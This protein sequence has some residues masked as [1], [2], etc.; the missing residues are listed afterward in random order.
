MLTDPKHPTWIKYTVQ[1]ES[2]IDILGSFGWLDDEEKA[3]RSQ[4]PWAPLIFSCAS[5]ARA[6]ILGRR[7]RSDRIRLF[8]C[9]GY[10]ESAQTISENI[11]QCQCLQKFFK[12]GVHS[13]THDWGWWFGHCFILGCLL[14][15]DHYGALQ[16]H[17]AV[18]SH[19]E[20]AWVFTAVGSAGS[21]QLLRPRQ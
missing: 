20:L 7:S 16:R 17:A 18:G 12:K 4:V 6:S 21:I 9:W 5:G 10:S 11:P 15:R 2:T 13:I 8:G 3:N 14:K 19:S 1:Q